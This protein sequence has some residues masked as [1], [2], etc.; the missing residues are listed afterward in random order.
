MPIIAVL[1]DHRIRFLLGLKSD[2]FSFI[3]TVSFIETKLV[4]GIVTL[5]FCLQNI[6][7]SLCVTFETTSSGGWSEGVK[8]T[9]QVS[10]DF[11]FS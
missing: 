5:S 8:V 7:E 11:R 4:D 10:F 3:P 6:V 1:Y 9:V 2:R